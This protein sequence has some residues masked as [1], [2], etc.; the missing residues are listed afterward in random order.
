MVCYKSEN[1]IVKQLCM[2]QTKKNINYFLKH[3]YLVQNVRRAKAGKT[4]DPKLC[5]VV[6]LIIW[7]LHFLVHK[8]PE[9]TKLRSVSFFTA[10]EL[11]KDSANIWLGPAAQA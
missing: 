11:H 2:L 10:F 5:S 7:N 1:I 9:E 8:L 3:N 6:Y 4:L